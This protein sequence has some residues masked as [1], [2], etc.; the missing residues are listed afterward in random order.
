M[1]QSGKS[2]YREFYSKGSGHSISNVYSPV[3]K[4]F[5]DVSG[6]SYDSVQL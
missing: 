3:Y 1:Y 4:Q 6:V 2:K 5:S